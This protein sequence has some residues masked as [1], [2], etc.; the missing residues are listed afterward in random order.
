VFN[1][2]ITSIKAEYPVLPEVNTLTINSRP[3]TVSCGC[4]SLSQSLR[5]THNLSAS[6]VF[7]NF[8]SRNAL[9]LP[10]QSQMGYKARDKSWRCVEH[11]LGV[12]Q[13]GVTS[14]DWTVFF[15]LLCSGQNWVFTFAIKALDLYSGKDKQS[16]FVLEI[17]S[18][19]MCSDNNI[20]TLIRTDINTFVP[21][22]TGAQ[23]LVVDSD[24]ITS[25]SPSSRKIDISVDGIYSDFQTFYD[26]LGLFGDSYWQNTPFE[27]RIN[28]EGG[29]AMTSAD[30]TSIIPSQPAFPTP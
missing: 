28:P 1:T 5:L 2:V 22:S 24:R 8:L 25:V 29:M 13:N 26:D 12:S 15:T 18:S 9:L 20:S 11:Y 3:V 6:K 10:Y 27:I 16:K 4:G 30:L 21:S 19:L 23:I 14:E 17:P 7:G